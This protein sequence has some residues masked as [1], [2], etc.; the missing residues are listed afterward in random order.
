MALAVGSV[1]CFA[2]CPTVAAH[3]VTGKPTVMPLKVAILVNL[4]SK[5]EFP[6]PFLQEI[7]HLNHEMQTALG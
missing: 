7:G 4:V 3:P 5:T 2:F 1:L 6:S